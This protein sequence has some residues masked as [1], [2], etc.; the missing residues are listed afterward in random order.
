M[1]IYLIDFENRPNTTGFSFLSASD[2]VVIFHTKKEKLSFEQHE[3]IKNSPAQID[4]FM[5]E[6][7]VSEALDKQLILLLGYLGAQHP[8]ETI[9]IVA[10]DKGYMITENLCKQLNISYKLIGEIPVKQKNAKPKAEPK[11]EAK[12]EDKKSDEPK[13]EAKEA[14]SIV[15]NKEEVKEEIKEEIK[16]DKPS[17][18]LT[19]S[20]KEELRNSGIELTEEDIDYISSLHVSL[21]DLM[22]MLKKRFGGDA[23]K[24]KAVKTLVEKFKKRNKIK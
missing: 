11:S 22:G 14:E 6:T 7:G 17:V 21:R 2:K 19:A 23:D 20:L 15:E 1:A 10:T 9:Y 5:A 18:D 13:E 4:S 24:A 16:E 3:D 8:N 12:V